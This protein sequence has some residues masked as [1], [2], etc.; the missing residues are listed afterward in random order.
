[1][2]ATRKKNITV[3]ANSDTTDGR[4]SGNEP[5]NHPYYRQACST[6]YEFFLQCH[7]DTYTHVRTFDQ[8]TKLL[9]IDFKVE[10]DSI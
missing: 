2:I 3:Q 10:I 6:G 1:M 5:Q 8:Y 7:E 9:C 4:R